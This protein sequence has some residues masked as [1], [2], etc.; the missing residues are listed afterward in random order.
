MT[1]YYQS[2]ID[3]FKTII[4]KGQREGQ[5]KAVNADMVAHSFCF[6]I[7]GQFF[8]SQAVNANKQLR[9]NIKSLL[10]AIKEMSFQVPVGN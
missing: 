5:F 8:I 6:M 7:M 3:K 4:R 2:A 10:E 9:F 1:S